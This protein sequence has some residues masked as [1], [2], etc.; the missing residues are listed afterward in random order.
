M[1]G[2]S[3]M[4]KKLVILLSIMLVIILGSSLVVAFAKKETR[5][6]DKLTIVTSFYPMYLLT[7]N[8]V[9][10]LNVEV[11]NLTDYKVGCLHDYQLTTLDMQKLN[12]ADVFIMNGGGM[13][14]FAEDVLKA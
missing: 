10:G 13:E 12:S 1:K 6:K 7:Q 5:Q 8:I 14:N 9:D 3:N 4:K 11:I 2:N